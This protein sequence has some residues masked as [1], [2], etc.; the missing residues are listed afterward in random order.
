MALKNLFLTWFFLFFLWGGNCPEGFVELDDNCYF[1]QHLD[2]LQDFIDSNT[3]LRTANPLK[4]GYQEWTNNR[5]TY[6]YLGELQITTL[7]DSIGLLKDLNSLDLRKN[8]ITTIPEG[9]CSIYPYY[10]QVN[11]SD[12]NICPPYPF[13]FDYIGNQD[14]KECESFKC[15]VGYEELQGE[16]YKADHIQVLQ[17]IIDSNSAL[18]GMR[19][20]ELGKDI[21]YQQWENGQLTHLN[22]VSNNLTRL[23]DNLC[24]IY[25]NLK[26]FDISNNSI[27]PPYPACFDFIGYQN[28]ENCTFS[29]DEDYTDNSNLTDN[30]EIVSYVAELNSDEFLNDLAVLQSFIDK[31][32]SLTGMHPLEIG[33]QSWSNMRL[34]SLDLSSLGLTYIPANFC[35]IYSNLNNFDV[36]NNFICP[37]YPQCLEYVSRQNTESCGDFFCPDNYTE[38]EGE[39]YHSDHIGFL[40]DLIDSNA[41]FLQVLPVLNPLEVG[42]NSGLLKWRQGK[43]ETLILNKN[44]LTILP[45]SICEIYGEIQA[46]DFSNNSICPPF[47]FC[48]QNIG[49]QNT[50]TCTQPLSCPDGDVAFDE[51]CYNS[52]DFQVLI[53]FTKINADIQAFHPLMLGYQV[54]KDNRL[55]QLYLNDL[56]ISEIPA[57]IQNLDRLEYLNLNNNNLEILPESLCNIYSN[58]VS[59]DLTNNFLCPPYLN[60]I[61]S[62]GKQNTENC[63]VADDSEAIGSLTNITANRAIISPVT[64]ISA[65]NTVYFQY[66]LSVLQSFIDKNETLAGKNP[67]EIGK[68]KW[69]NMRLVSL[70]LSSLGLTYIPAKFCSIYSNLNNFDVGNNFICPPYPTCI[71]YVSKQQTESCGDSFCP[72]NYT[73]IEGDCYYTEHLKILQDIIDN[74]A[75]LEGKSPLDIGDDNGKQNWIGGKLNQLILVGNKLTNMPV[76]ICDIYSNLSVFD[77]TNNFICSPYPP[78]IEDVGFQNVEACFH[79]PSCSEGDVL[80]DEKCYYFDDLQVL[81]DFTKINDSIQAY[82]PLLLGYQVW[83]NNRLQQLNLDG[84][85]ITEI[86]N[87]IDRLDQLEYLNLNNNKLESLPETLCNIY[88]H[89]KSLEI[90]NNLLCPP[91]L[92][93]FDYIGHQNTENCEYSFCPYGYLDIDEECYF[94]KDISTL[95]DFISMNKSLTG[96]TPLDIGVQKWKNMRLH[97]LYLGV[98][99][100]TTIPE[101]VCE[102]ISQLKTFNISQNNICQPY[103]ACVEEYIGEQDGT[104]CP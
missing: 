45:E 23:P 42:E 101:S 48:I 58:L 59:V 100:L 29:S 46:L 88:P 83:K 74:N 57:S 50:D 87:S 82:H 5:L 102:L 51:K 49:N 10:S 13:C 8:N 33:R 89:F 41:A 54:W 27:C 34:V 2:V 28:T 30:L 69:S 66:D 79:S 78:C 32:E 81:I 65:I 53:D 73:E 44:N 47:P 92:E 21:G 96:R 20:L 62:I 86:P 43:I 26:L 61:N 103:P 90:T 91:Y 4:I 56:A 37:P 85:G 70:D 93:C 6:L 31:N 60:C 12:N 94:E 25:K 14:T 38:I 77:M 1:K 18:N 9:I 11:F 75:S 52:D 97:Y 76:S 16:C 63:T 36:G 95:Q 15:P 99:Q 64:D 3:S 40:E 22:L 104:N 17:A 19:P 24:T 71:E 39:C 98:N 84:W 7:P 55:H 68:Q 72:D 67:L 80:F 35:S